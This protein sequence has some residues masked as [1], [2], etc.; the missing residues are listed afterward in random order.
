MPIRF[1]PPIALPR[2]H[3]GVVGALAFRTASSPASGRV[4]ELFESSETKEQFVMSLSEISPRTRSQV[5]TKVWAEPH[6][7]DRRLTHG[8]LEGGRLFLVESI[9]ES[10]EGL[11]LSLR[12]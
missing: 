10:R 8:R 4:G 3:L 7:T 5:R 9:W 11:P 1:E 2:M 6:G 12:L